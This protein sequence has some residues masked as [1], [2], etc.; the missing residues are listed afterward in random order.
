VGVPLAKQTQLR[1]AGVVSVAPAPTPLVHLS[2]I[3]KRFGGFTANDDVSLTI[4]ERQIHALLGENGAGKSTLVKILFGLLQPDAGT[5]RWKGLAVSIPSPDAARKLGIAM[6]FQHFSLF[7]N[8]S[9]LENLAL[10]LPGRVADDALA[11]ETSALAKRYGLAI[12]L[13]A[14]VWSLSAGERQR[15]EIVRALV[16]KPKLLVLD[17]PTSVLTP[18]E[19]EGLFQTL[20]KLVEDGASVLFIS[21]KLDE[22]R[23]LCSAATILRGGK[24]VAEVDPRRESSRSL[25][26]LM[27]GAEVRD[28][29]RISQSD[30]VGRGA[31]ILT[32]SGLNASP[33]DVHG[34]PLRDISLEVASG[35]IVAIAGVAGGGQTELFA[36]LSGEQGRAVSGRI[37]IGGTDVASAPISLR[38]ALGAAF[39]PEDRLGHG[40]L[41]KGSL[42]SNLILTLPRA[43]AAGRMGWLD[44]TGLGRKLSEITK[45]FDVRASAADPEARRLSGG[46]LQKYVIGREILRKPKLLV[47]NQPTWGVDA[48]ATQRIREA[49]MKLADEGAAVLVISQD[50]DEVFALADRIAVIRAGRL[51]PARPASALTREDVGLLMTEGGEG[52]AHAA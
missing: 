20:D 15:I 2:G 27:V 26:A 43:E 23:R 35:E 30:A 9:V 18:Q 37:S 38:R 40:T 14:P 28:A 34:V 46:N 1:F 48:L 47:I 25:A 41:P 19:A 5:I 32:I 11:V 49:L 16:Q 4:G 6:V 39:V 3:V 44:R 12:H 31:P 7:E 10:G 24:V 17:E 13:E 36:M 22:V 52:M 42:S 8:L 33:A 29:R 50:L 21:H 45:A 51:S